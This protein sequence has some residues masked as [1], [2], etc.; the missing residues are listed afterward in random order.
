[1]GTHAR[2]PLGTQEGLQLALGANRARGDQRSSRRGADSGEGLELAER[3][4]VEVHSNSLELASGVGRGA[5][6]DSQPGQ[7]LDAQGQSP[8]REHLSASQGDRIARTHAPALGKERA[9]RVKP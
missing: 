6:H 5:A 8:G 1:M 4:P 7:S 9:P 3:S 2:Q